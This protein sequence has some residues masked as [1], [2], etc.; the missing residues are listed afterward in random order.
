MADYIIFP[1]NTGS[2]KYWFLS[3]ISSNRITAKPGNYM[4]VKETNSGWVPI[5]V[6]IADNLYDR[7]HN[8]E[9]WQEAQ[10]LGASRV[11][12]HINLDD[13][14]KSNEEVDLISYWNPPLN[15]Q[16]RTR[17]ISSILGQG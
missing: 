1:G 17:P 2:Y 15:T 8:H 13:Q 9:K 16:H 4:F 10:G 6:G 12:A 3:D 14:D 7:L 5:Y 11:I